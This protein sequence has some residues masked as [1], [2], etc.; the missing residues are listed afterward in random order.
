MRNHLG[1]G[2]T[3]LPREPGGD[4]G[5]PVPGTGGAPASLHRARRRRPPGPDDERLTLVTCH[6]YGS[7]RYRLIVVAH[8]VATLE[9]EV[10][11]LS[12]EGVLSEIAASSM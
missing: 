12:L 2:G 1:P 6:P 11:W 10:D 7:L 9:D 3:L 4:G 8:P 5:R